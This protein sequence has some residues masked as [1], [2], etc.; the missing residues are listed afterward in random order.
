MADTLVD[1]V[2][3][4]KNAGRTDAVIRDCRKLLALSG[5]TPHQKAFSF[6]CLAHAAIVRGDALSASQYAQQA[7]AAEPTN[8]LARINDLKAACMQA[9]P[10]QQIA[11]KA[12]DTDSL[13]RQRGLSAPLKDT[14]LRHICKNYGLTWHDGP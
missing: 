10:A 7:L 1:D 2:R 3:A 4:E 8:Y 13:R 12:A 14:E 11:Q 9:L 5:I 6:D